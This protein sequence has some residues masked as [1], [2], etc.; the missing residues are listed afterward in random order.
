MHDKN[1]RRQGEETFAQNVTIMMISCQ[2]TTMSREFNKIK[3]ASI[4]LLRECS[5]FN[6]ISWTFASGNYPSQT[7]D[8]TPKNF[9]SNQNS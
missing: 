9:A 5:L 8:K 7:H 3:N 6:K 1:V 2:K 4:K